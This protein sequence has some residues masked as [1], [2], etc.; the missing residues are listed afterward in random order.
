MREGILLVLNAE[1]YEHEG[2]AGQPS[3]DA[4]LPLLAGIGKSVIWKIYRG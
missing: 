1:R 3:I 2:W 4:N